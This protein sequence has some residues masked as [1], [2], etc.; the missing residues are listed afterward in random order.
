MSAGSATNEWSNKNFAG[1]ALSDVVYVT[2]NPVVSRE[3]KTAFR[4][5]IE[6]WQE[7][8]DEEIGTVPPEAVTN[9]AIDAM[10]RYPENR[11]IVHYL[12]PHYPFINYPELQYGSFGNT[13]EI[14]AKSAKEGANHVWT[15]LDKG[16]VD[17]QTVWEAY[18]DNLHLVMESVE[19]LLEEADGR[20]VITSD[21]GNLIGE[22]ATPLRIPLYGHPPNIYHE[23][24]RRIP[25]AVVNEKEGSRGDDVEDKIKERLRSLGYK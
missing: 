10:K 25:W 12:Q 6:V 17:E 5:F 15:A 16:F 21:H 24:L 13:E 19:E 22:R 8:F 18:R 20:V 11:I 14:N 7:E 3:V 1:Q 23:N 9:A 4:A 2:G